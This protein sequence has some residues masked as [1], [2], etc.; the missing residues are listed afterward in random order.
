MADSDGGEPIDLA[1]EKAKRARAKK[2]P[3]AANGANGHAAHANA[4][5]Q[6]KKNGNLENNVNNAIMMLQRDH[7]TSFRFNE[8]ERTIRFLKTG[9]QLTD[10]D[11]VGIQQ[12]MQQCGMYNVAKDTVHDAIVFVAKE[13]GFH[14]IREWLEWLPE[15]DG[16]KRIDYLFSTYFGSNPLVPTEYELAIGRMF[17]MGMVAR[18]MRPGC[19][20]DY[21][22]VIEGPQGVKKSTA[23]RALAG[24]EYFGDNLP[25]PGSKDACS[26]L[27]GLWLVEVAELTA[28]KGARATTIKAFLTR[29]EER[30]RPPYAR[31]EVLEKRQCVFAGTTNQDTYLEDVTGGR[32]FW[33]VKAGV[34]DVEMIKR[35]REMLF[36]E[37]LCRF[38]AGE[39]YWPSQKQE[40]EWFKPE[41][42]ARFMEDS[43]EQPIEEFILGRT[44]F[45]LSECMRALGYDVSKQQTAAQRQ[46]T[47]AIERVIRRIGGW[48]RM[49]RSAKERARWAKIQY[50]DTEYG[51]ID[52]T[53]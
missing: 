38:K 29:Q 40:D 15:W 17:M 36:A 52:I 12:I 27:R 43:L 23:L 9:E 51:R 4:G 50:R 24:E 6:H 45:T 28:F 42:E 26:Y 34:I 25:D 5:L 8:L 37:A 31:T 20:F 22:P 41:Q 49:P 32:R 1:I 46:F 39:E 16:V 44:E 53:R 18:V 47:K 30:Y 2:G 7:A 19:K 13:N 21:M 33:P 3:K 48:K 35:D 10:R 14:P 11:T